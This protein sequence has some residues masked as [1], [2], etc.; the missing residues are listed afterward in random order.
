MKNLMVA[1]KQ[2]LK[3][4]SLKEFPRDEIYIQKSIP[5]TEESM[6]YLNGT[7][8][9]NFVYFGKELFISADSEI[10]DFAYQYANHYKNELFRL[11]DAP[12]IFHL[13]NE[14]EKYGYTVAH[15]AQYFLLDDSRP[16]KV[17][18]PYSLEVLC[19]EQ[20]ET[21]YN[22][23]FDMALCG[24]TTGRR[25][26]VLAVVCKID[27]QIAGVAGCTND[28]EELW[29]IGVDVLPKYQKKGIGTVLVC[30]LSEEILKLGKYPFYCCAWSNLASK[31][32]ARKA[33]FVDAWVE[34]SAKS[35]EEEW[36]KKIRR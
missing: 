1:K 25:C 17:D 29:Q 9:L 6:K 28:G 2:F 8:F 15:L 26:D 23:G 22:L 11:F 31:R 33:G 27:N 21:L 18:S 30:R 13:N 7:P 14:L 4:Y 35:I 32:L 19:K 36:I 3:D 10:Y 12:N 24:T 16:V 20:I 34:L 5:F